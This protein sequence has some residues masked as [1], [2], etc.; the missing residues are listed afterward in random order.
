[1]NKEEYIVFSLS[2]NKKLARELAKSLSAPLGKV[3]ITHFADGEIM[4]KTL[5]N[6]ENKIAI[7]VQSTSR[8]AHEKL[9]EV[10]LLL[11][12]I[13]RSKAKKVQLIMPYFGYSRQER[14]SWYNE[15]VSCE[16]V[17]RV[18]NTTGVD[19]LLMFDL[20]HPDIESFFTLNIKDIPTTSLFASYYKSYF[21]KRNIL[22][23]DVVIVSPDHGANN[24]GSMLQKE[25]EDSSFLLLDK[26]R[27]QVNSAE[28]LETSA[29]LSGKYCVI[30]D[31]IVDTGGTIVSAS[32]LLYSH[33]AKEVLLGASHAVFSKNC[34]SKLKDA[35]IKDIV[36]T[37]TIERKLKDNITPLDILPIVLPHIIK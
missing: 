27:P 5:S 20:H 1:M 35:N 24:R 12:S 26:V 10:L 23:K 6:V 25:L 7:V 22:L 28:H 13:K 2:T 34:L 36:V 8:P 3:K 31:D 30:I 18:L 32:S 15:P 11:D 37:N 9:F 16:V 19:S 14:V 17:A 29:D 4:V 33:N 21:E